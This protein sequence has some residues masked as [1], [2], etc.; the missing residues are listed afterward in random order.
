MFFKKAVFKNFKKL[1][2]KQLY[3][4]LIFNKVAGQLYQKN[5][6]TQVISCKF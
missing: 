1:T 6:P 4:S 2:G 3:W 5:T